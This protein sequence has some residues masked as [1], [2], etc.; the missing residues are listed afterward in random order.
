ME[1]DTFNKYLVS[2]KGECLLMLRPPQ[3]GEALTKSEALL[4]AAYLVALAD[5]EDA[6]FPRMLKAVRET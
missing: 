1:I 3:L 5:P 6:E 2:V 4:L